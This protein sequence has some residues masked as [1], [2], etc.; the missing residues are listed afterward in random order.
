MDIF[1]SKV[2]LL[3]IFFLSWSNSQS[4]ITRSTEGQDLIIVFDTTT[5]MTDDIN[6]LRIH[7]IDVV[8]RFEKM[9]PNP[10]SNYILV[11][12]K[13][14]T[15]FTP[16]KTKDKNEFIAFLNGMKAKSE[17]FLNCAEEC[18]A[19][20]EVALNTARRKPYIF[21]FTDAYTNQVHKKDVIKQLISKTQ[22]KIY[23]FMASY[24]NNQAFEQGEYRD[25]ATASNGLFFGTKRANVG[26][27]K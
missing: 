10:I 11:E 2:I 22:A 8:N 18:Y 6:E 21:V 15:V 25:I 4:T 24:C 1:K 13:D 17:N 20:I 23:F 27:V 9:K 7:A 16:K 14:P 5:S 3:L 19:A 26:Q 12:F